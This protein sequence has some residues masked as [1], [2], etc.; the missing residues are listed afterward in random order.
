MKQ[1]LLAFGMLV[2]SG[3]AFAQ[4]GPQ[5]SLDKDVHDYGT[6]PQGANGT[7]EFVVTIWLIS[8]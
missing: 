7:C 1:F 5:I 8:P 3:S 4:T 6:I 2:L